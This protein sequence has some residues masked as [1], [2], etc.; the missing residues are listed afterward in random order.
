MLTLPQAMENNQIRNDFFWALGT[1]AESKRFKR[2]YDSVLHK[3]LVRLTSE[4]GE[5]ITLRPFYYYVTYNIIDKA[6]QLIIGQDLV[7]FLEGIPVPASPQQLQSLFSGRLDHICMFVSIDFTFNCYIQ[8][9][10]H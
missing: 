7:S 3:L 6:R 10:Y 4:K 2:L 5:G 8:V 1:C 9:E